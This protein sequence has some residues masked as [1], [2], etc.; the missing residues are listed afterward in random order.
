MDLFSLNCKLVLVVFENGFHR[1]KQEV[2]LQDT[3]SLLFVMPSHA[4][5][6]RF[7]DDSGLELKQ[8]RPILV[9]LALHSDYRGRK[10]LIDD[11]ECKHPVVNR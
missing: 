1:L 7:L 8:A 2:L 5:W 4:F 6:Y 11:S 9:D 10:E 3:A